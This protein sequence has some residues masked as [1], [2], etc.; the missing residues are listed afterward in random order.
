VARVDIAILREIVR[1]VGTRGEVPEFVEL[2]KKRFQVKYLD[3]HKQRIE[4]ALRRGD[5]DRLNM[6]YGQLESKVKYQVLRGVSVVKGTEPAPSV[7][8][9]SRPTAKTVVPPP[10][11]KPAPPRA[12][13][14]SARV[15]PKTGGKTGGKQATKPGAPEKRSLK[16]VATTPGVAP[17]SAKPAA[18]PARKVPARNPAK[19]KK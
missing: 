13:P 9:S 5:R 10:Q 11:G 2:S 4:E 17:A 12:E 3:D 15:E 1:V 14:S 7:K 16:P 19:K 6:L 18:V 8:G